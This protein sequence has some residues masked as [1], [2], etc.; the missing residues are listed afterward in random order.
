MHCPTTV[1]MPSPSAEQGIFITEA[2]EPPMAFAAIAAVPRVLTKLLTA[3]LPNWKIPFSMPL[4]MPI[5]KMRRITSFC[6]SSDF[7]L[8]SRNGLC[9]VC[10]STNTITAA[11]MRESKV[12]NAAPNTPQPNPKINSALPETFTTFMQRLANM[13]IL[14]LPCARNNAA[15]PLYNPMNG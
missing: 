9:P 15:T 7:R 3:S 11:N 6:G 4:G 13:L 8:S 12:A 10:S 14:L 5:D 2:T 1:M